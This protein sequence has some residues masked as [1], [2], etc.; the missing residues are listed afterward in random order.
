[1]S[2]K[3]EWKN[4]RRK[5]DG[6]RERALCQ[7]RVEVNL[8]RVLNYTIHGADII[9]PPHRVITVVRIFT[10][11]AI[12]LSTSFRFSSFRYCFGS[13]G[14]ARLIVNRSECESKMFATVSVACHFYAIDDF[15]SNTIGLCSSF[16]LSLFF[17]RKMKT[18]KMHFSHQILV[19]LNT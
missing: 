13:F 10:I 7:M 12:L 15:K 8:W 5:R 16:I 11:T 2:I 4:G 9:V 14:L 18:K 1:M 3:Q 19:N 17:L 6:E